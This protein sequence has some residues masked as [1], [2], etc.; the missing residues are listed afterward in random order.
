MVSVFSQA[1]YFFFF[2]IFFFSVFKEGAGVRG[3]FFWSTRDEEGSF[4]F[5]PVVSLNGIQRGPRAGVLMR[6]GI[7]DYHRPSSGVS[8]GA[9]VTGEESGAPTSRRQEK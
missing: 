9:P 4:L 8:S 3:R 5:L 7:I 1:G 6:C 2:Q